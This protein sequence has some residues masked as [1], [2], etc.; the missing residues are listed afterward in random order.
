MSLNYANGKIYKLQCQDDYYHIGCTV[1]VLEYKFNNIKQSSNKNPELYP[2]INTIG[3]DKVKIALLEAY[4]CKSKAEL[5]LRMNYHINQAQQQRNK[6]CLNVVIDDTPIE[7]TTKYAEGKIYMLKC[8]DGFYYY[9]STINTLT[10]RMTDHKKDSKLHA[11]R[12]VYI[13][14]NDIGWDEVKCILVENYPCATKKELNEREDYYINK[15][16]KENDMFC[17]NFN[18]ASVSQVE[19][20]DKQ[21]QYR[22]ENKS[23]IKKYKKEYRAANAD[24]IRDYNKAY[25]EE[26]SEQVRAAQKKHYE[27]NKEQI[28]AVNRAY[29]EA[30]KEK[31]DAYKRKWAIEQREKNADAIAAAKAEKKAARQKKSEERIARDN[32]IITCAC[33]G[34]YQPYRKS[35]H[36]TG[37]KHLAFVAVV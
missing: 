6:F 19:L 21:K 13:H 14:I 2:H 26:N 37:K 33:G 35:R 25:A 15:A 9:G 1:S 17:L 29:T 36:D 32:E 34:T 30:N 10:K 23:K 24:I 3:W 8:T 5:E 7:N 22:E 27:E 12:Y 16:Q 4:P 31:V 18:R 11:D 20:K 28:L